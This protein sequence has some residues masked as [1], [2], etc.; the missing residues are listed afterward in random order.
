MCTAGPVRAA[1][2]PLKYVVDVAS[3]ILVMYHD[4]GQGIMVIFFVLLWLLVLVVAYQTADG[5]MAVLLKSFCGVS[6]NA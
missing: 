5:M 3:F 2:K 1:L 4:A 6:W